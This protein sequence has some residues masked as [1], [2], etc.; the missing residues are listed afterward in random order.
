ME[1]EK[2]KQLCKFPFYVYMLEKYTH[3]FLFAQYYI[4]LE[5]MFALY[6]IERE[7][8]VLFYKCAHLFVSI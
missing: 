8:I 5:D 3:F 4:T 1:E 7:K 6:C 2:K